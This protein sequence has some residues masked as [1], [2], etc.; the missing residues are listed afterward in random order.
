MKDIIFTRDEIEPT[1]GEIENCW[2]WEQEGGGAG[3]PDGRG[4]GVGG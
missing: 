1:R 4:C 2:G 3:G